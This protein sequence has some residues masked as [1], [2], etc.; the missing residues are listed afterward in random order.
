MEAENIDILLYMRYV[1]DCRDFLRPLYEGWRWSTEKLRFEFS[2]EAENEDF[3]EGM[4][5]QARTTRELVKAI[6]FNM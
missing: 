5:D 1:D 2:E 4:T 6:F 3:E